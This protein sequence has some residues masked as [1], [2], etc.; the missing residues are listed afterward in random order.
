MNRSAVY[1]SPALCKAALKARFRF[2]RRKLFEL[3]G[4]GKYTA[5]PS[6]NGLDAKLEK[7]L[8]FKRGFFIEAGGNDGFLQSNT[9][10]L[11]FGKRW[12]GL[13]VEPVPELFQRCQA[14]RK[15]SQVF[16]AALVAP[17]HEDRVVKIHYAGLMS[18]GEG[19]MPA[20]DLEEHV[21]RGMDL[22][23]IDRSYV[24]EAPARTLESILDEAGI[25]T[26]K[27]DFLSLD[28]EGGELAALEG[29]NLAKYRPEYILVEARYYDEVDRFLVSNS[30]VQ[31]EKMSM[32]DYLYGD[33]EAGFGKGSEPIAV[34]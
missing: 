30:Y 24:V 31:L 9:F 3:C 6:L 32:H 7:Y 12:R 25:G 1:Q 13:L 34:L 18:V 5:R 29:L 11:E 23:R 26:R 21:R 19:A 10:Y 27:I 2:W 28:I 15:R 22:Q 20:G 16:H 17:S 14:L 8:D 4:S 33:A